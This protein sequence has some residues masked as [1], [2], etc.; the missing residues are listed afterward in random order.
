MIVSSGYL[1]LGQ[2]LQLIVLGLRG[3]GA[4]EVEIMVLWHQVAVLRR[5]VKRLDLEPNDRAVLS[6]LSRLLPRPRLRSAFRCGRDHAAVE[7]GG[8]VL[9]HATSLSLIGD[10]PLCGGQVGVGSVL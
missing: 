4:K 7:F 9:E 6:A 8:E 5:Q 10:D 3:D 1:V 2:L